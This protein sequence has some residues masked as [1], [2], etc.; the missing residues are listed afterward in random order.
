[1]IIEVFQ[2]RDGGGAEEGHYRRWRDVGN[3]EAQDASEINR[4]GRGTGVRGKVRKRKMKNNS[5]R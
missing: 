1:M 2:E 4:V 3:G 5:E